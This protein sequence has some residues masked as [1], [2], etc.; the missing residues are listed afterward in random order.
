VLGAG[1]GLAFAVQ[2]LRRRVDRALLAAGIFVV[3]TF[4]AAFVVLFRGQAQGLE[5]DPLTTILRTPLVKQVL[6]Q[7]PHPSAPLLAAFTVFALL[8]WGAH[9][10]G[11]GV[12]IQRHW[13]DPMVGVLTGA[14]LAGFAGAL[15]TAQAG[16]SQYYF[17]RAGMPLGG[18]LTAWGLALA[19]D[20]LR[21]TPR[22]TAVFAVAAAAVGLGGAAAVATLTG[23]GR[24]FPVHLHGRSLVAHVL[25]PIALACAIC[26]GAALLA[27]APGIRARRR[28]AVAAVLVAVAAAGLLRLGT[29]GVAGARFAARYG[30]A[31]GTQG[32]LIGYPVTPAGLAAARWL[33]DH[34]SPDD[35][36]ATNLHCR[37]VLG[38][39]CDNRQFWLAALSERRILVEGWGYTSRSNAEYVARPTIKVYFGPYWDAAR[40]R[41]NDL[42]FTDPTPERLAL[43]RDRWGVR[44]LFV[45]THA[46]VRPNP[47]LDRLADLRFANREARVYELR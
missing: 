5:V 16:S 19:L 10:A 25:L 46:G 23:A 45:H 21:L 7:V 8:S 37:V 42:A 40:M 44:W 4:G 22:R 32:D 39:Y 14:V 27:L 26:L 18:I 20:R 34:S 6:G 47:D 36:V 24:A 41:A 9:L 2:L 1:L 3:V 38:K 11:A 17:L 35:V 12:V 30:T 15:L 33:R 31:T 43:L 29:D 28:A 13:R